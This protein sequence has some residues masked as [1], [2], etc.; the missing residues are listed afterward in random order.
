M[1]SASAPAP[2]PLATAP[3]QSGELESQGRDLDVLSRASGL[4]I[5]AALREPMIK[6]LADLRRMIAV[7]RESQGRARD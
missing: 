7:L 6:E 2:A 5:P 4:D 1:T 3:P